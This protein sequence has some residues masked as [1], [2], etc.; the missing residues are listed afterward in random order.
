RKMRLGQL[1][2]GVFTGSELS[3][4]YPDS[5]LYSLPFLFRDWDEVAAVRARV[6]PL[7]AEGFERH[8]LRMLGLS[9]VGF[10]YIMGNK[11]LRSQADVAGIK[12]W[13][14]QTGSIAIR[15]VEL[16]GISPIP[17]PIGDV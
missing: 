14:P 15:P 12:L 2:G 7:L 17:L 16:G 5:Q 3:L 8:G 4:V 1:Q 11:P 10:A 9:G 13:V 6:D